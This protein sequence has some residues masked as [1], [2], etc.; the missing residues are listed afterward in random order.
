MASVDLKI[1]GKVQGV[2]FR[3]SVKVEA[4]KLSLVGW[5]RNDSDGTV[6]V[7]AV[8][9]KDKLDLLIKW[10]QK[11]PDGAKVESIEVDWNET[12]DKFS[13]FDIL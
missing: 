8:G 10:C 9:S 12:A 3:Q 5:T 13:S 6:E 7:L 4:D 2:F 11:G 1:Y